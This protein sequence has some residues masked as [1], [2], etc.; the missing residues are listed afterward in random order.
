MILATLVLCFVVGMS[1][2]LINSTLEELVKAT[3][4][5]RRGRRHEN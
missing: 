4:E 2:L 5:Y 1:A 3:R